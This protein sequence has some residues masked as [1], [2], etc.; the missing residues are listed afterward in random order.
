MYD[1]IFHLLIKLDFK[2][3]NGEGFSLL[4]S[5]VAFDNFHGIIL[6]NIELF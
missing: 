5:E 6:M 1:I 2:R 3:F 4:R